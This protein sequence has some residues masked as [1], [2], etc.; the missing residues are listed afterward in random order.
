MSFLALVAA[1]FLQ[2]FRPFPDP[3]PVSLWL[4]R[5]VHW[6][7]GTANAGLR[8]YGVAGWFAVM[9][10]IFIP[11]TLAYYILDAIGAAFAW[12]FAVVIL[13][14]AIRFRAALAHLQSVEQAL[15][16]HDLA[17]AR[18]ALAAWL[19]RPVADY[20]RGQIVRVALERALLDCYRG[21]FGVLFWFVV[22]PGPAGALMYR[23]AMLMAER[24]ADQRPSED[25]AFGWFAHRMAEVVDWLPQRLT[26]F[27]FAVVGDFED[28]LYCWRSQSKSW[29]SELEGVVLASGAG[30][31]GVRIGEPV[32]DATGPVYRVGLG[33]GDEAE[34]DHLRSAEGLIW[35]AA[36]LWAGMLLLL[37]IFRVVA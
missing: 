4:A 6:I 13:Y 15:R 26:A 19:N 3:D 17:A 9:L 5:L 18:E 27:S 22:L 25:Y 16:A 11:V 28:A 14:L 32:N 29:G 8:P 30:A 34:A 10:I 37:A 23:A 24:W 7:E 33:L 31:L 21:L 20:D 1:L 36:V 2:K 12:L 35:R